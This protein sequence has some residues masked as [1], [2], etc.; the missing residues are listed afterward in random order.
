MSVTETVLYF[1]VI[2]AA[3]VL[4]IA[5]LA[6]AGGG[7]R[8]KRYRPGRPY[9]FRPVW[10]LSAP[11]LLSHAP[12]EA[13]SHNIEVGETRALTTAG[14]AFGGP[15]GAIEPVPSAAPAGKV[16]GASDRW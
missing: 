5:G 7:P 3:A 1:V 10:F 14:S 6:A 13:D 4:V 8:P 16:G 2:P 11:E 12:E 15:T 9:D